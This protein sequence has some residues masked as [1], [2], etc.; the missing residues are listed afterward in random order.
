M[1]VVHDFPHGARGLRVAWLCEEMGLPYTIKHVGFPT[2][3]AYRALNPF[4]TVPFLQDGKV[5][6]SESVAMLFY[7]AQRYGP[8]DTLPWKDGDEHHARVLQ[9]TLFGEAALASPMTPLLTERFGAPAEHK[10]NWSTVGIEFPSQ[11]RHR[12]LEPP[13]R[14]SRIPGRRRIDPGR[15]FRDHRAADLV[16][17]PWSGHLAGAAGLLRAA[18]R[19]AGMQASHR[20]ARQALADRHPARG[21]PPPGKIWRLSAAA[22]PATVPRC[23]WRP[24]SIPPKSRRS[25]PA[26]PSSARRCRHPTPSAGRRYG[27]RTGTSSSSH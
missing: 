18:A 9:F 3:G 21:H 10:R 24:R 11:V 20:L 7:L 16:E 12:P 27:H 6:M 13:T 19:T 2:D 15:Y 1:I 25:R 8:T 17:R 4:G 5:S 23:S 22:L 14:R 26:I